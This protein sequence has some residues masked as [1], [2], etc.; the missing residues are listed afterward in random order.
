MSDAP[1]SAPRPPR[2]GLPLFDLIISVCALVMS[3]VSI[4]MANQNS[5]SMQDLVHANSWPFLQVDSG[6]TSD[7][8]TQHVLQFGVSNAGVG[9][10]RI[11]SSAFLVDGRPV[12]GTDIF[13]KIARG[14]CESE[15]QSITAGTTNPYDALGDVMTSIVAPKVLA[16]RDSVVALRW[17]R[18]D[19]NA[20]LWAAIDQA[21]QHGR[22]TMR[23]CYC[24]VFNEC[25]IGESNELPKPSSACVE[26]Q[27]PFSPHRP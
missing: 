24:S 10:A 21:R 9:P 14:C 20:A 8:G 22:I 18:T 2:S 25:W 16:A 17:A 7:D 5:N 15:Y 3:A 23:V 1:D 4:F 13:A 12:H 27:S 11:Y 19:R 26:Q 6:N